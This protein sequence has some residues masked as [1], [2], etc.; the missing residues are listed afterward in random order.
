MEFETDWNSLLDDDRNTILSSIVDIPFRNR[1]VLLAII[2]LINYQL[3]SETSNYI[4]V[5]VRT[6]GMI[7]ILISGSAIRYQ[8]LFERDRQKYQDLSIE[9]PDRFE[10]LIV[11]SKETIPIASVYLERTDTLEESVF[12]VQSYQLNSKFNDYLY[13]IVNYTCKIVIE[14]MENYTIE[15]E[16]SVRLV[17]PLPM[18]KKNW[19][20]AIKA[21]KFILN[22]TYRD[23]SFMPFV[24]SYVEQYEYEQLV[25][26]KDQ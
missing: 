10:R 7:I 9:K 19:T 17:W 1:W 23:F 5:V 6:I 20:F 16:K 22:K 2:I 24:H 18:C 8:T 26:K 11:Y 3:N 13:D 4:E 15:N 12:T 25:S 14:R 21:N